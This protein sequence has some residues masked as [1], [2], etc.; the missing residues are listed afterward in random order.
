MQTLIADCRQLLHLN[1]F[2]FFG[3]MI[4]ILEKMIKE[5][6]IFFLLLVVIGVGFLQSFFAYSISFK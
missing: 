3:T 5:T 2:R 6:A 1:F 4:V